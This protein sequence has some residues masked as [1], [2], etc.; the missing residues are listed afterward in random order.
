MGVLAVS[1]SPFFD[2]GYLFTA[3]LDATGTPLSSEFVGDLVDE[4]GRADESVVVAAATHTL[5]A[6]EDGRND[7]LVSPA[8]YP[9]PM[10]TE[11]VARRIAPREPGP[12]YPDRQIGLIGAQSIDEGDTLR[13]R[14]TAPGLS[15][16]A[17]FSAAG[18]PAGA[19]FDPASRIIQWRPAGNQ[20]GTYG[21]IVLSATDGVASASETIAITVH[22]ALASITGFVRLESGGGVGSVAVQVRGTADRQRTITTAAD[23]TYRLEGGLKAG[24][25]VKVKLARA[26]RRQYRARPSTVRVIATTGDI[27]MPDL[28]VTPR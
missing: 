16:A 7:P 10:F 22:D 9:H 1:D 17:I 21:G 4:T 25:A 13:F 14:V 15:P 5:V 3:R 18:L 26:M 23:G 24:K 6:W 2:G 19:V 27:Q 8:A 11:H 12:M 28:V 20:A